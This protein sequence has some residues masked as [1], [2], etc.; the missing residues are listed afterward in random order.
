MSWAETEYGCLYLSCVRPRKGNVKQPPRRQLV[1]Q[2]I[3]LHVGGI[4]REPRVA[5]PSSLSHDPK[6][7]P[8]KAALFRLGLRDPQGRVEGR[9]WTLGSPPSK[10][11][12]QAAWVTGRDHLGRVAPEAPLR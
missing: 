7:S 4:R 6:R 1:L 9:A 8:L 12:P 5:L 10:L 2:E 3:I 11:T